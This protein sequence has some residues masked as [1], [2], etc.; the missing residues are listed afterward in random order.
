MSLLRSTALWLFTA[1][2]IAA[3]LYLSLVADWQ[4]PRL[5]SAHFTAQH[6]VELFTGEG[7][8]AASLWRSLLLALAV[9]LTCTFLGFVFAGFLVLRAGSLRWFQLAVYPYLISP[10]VLGTMLHFYFV[11]LGLA[12]QMAGVFLAQVLFI[13][14][15]ATLV[16]YTFWTARKRAIAHECQSLGATVTQLYRRVLVPMARPWI[17]LCAVQCFLLSW[18]EYGLTRVVGMGK[19]QTLTVEV[20]R[21][22]AEANLHYAAAS[23]VLMFI[24]P[25]LLA[26]AALTAAKKIVK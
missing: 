5:I 17:G 18:F 11:W 21:Y 19:V 7:G 15:Y 16:F 9:A 13:A 12:G 1:A 6:W 20:M 25:A 2:P 22:T 10:V 4:Y 3:L 24:P 26:I 8:L 14:P 23:G